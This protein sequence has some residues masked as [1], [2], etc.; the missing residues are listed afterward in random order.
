MLVS[1]GV[2]GAVNAS[3]V[4]VVFL[5]RIPFYSLLFFSPHSFSLAFS[6]LWCMHR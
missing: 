4:H 1:S 2:T 3:F 6:A 5:F